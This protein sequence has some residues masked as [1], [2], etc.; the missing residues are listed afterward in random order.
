M[1]VLTVRCF[2]HTVQESILVADKG[3]ILFYDKFILVLE[4]V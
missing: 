2:K 3:A 4:T 1:R